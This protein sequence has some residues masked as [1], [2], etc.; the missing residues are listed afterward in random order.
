MN[1]RLIDFAFAA[2]T[3]AIRLPEFPTENPASPAQILVNPAS[4]VEGKSRFP[5]KDFAFF[6]NPSPYFGQFQDPENTLPDPK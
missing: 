3:Y 2:R 6:T 5:S 1:A 4:R